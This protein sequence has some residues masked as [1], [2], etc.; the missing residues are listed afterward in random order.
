MGVK[1]SIIKRSFRHKYGNLY[2]NGIQIWE[3]GADH[4]TKWDKKFCLQSVIGI[5]R[6]Q[7]ILCDLSRLI[8][9]R[10]IQ[11]KDKE[12]V[13]RRYYRNWFLLLS[14]FFFQLNRGLYSFAQK[15]RT[16]NL[17]LYQSTQLRCSTC[18]K[19]AGP[20]EIPI[21]FPLY[22]FSSSCLCVCV[23]VDVQVAKLGNVL[24]PIKMFFLS[25]PFCWI[26]SLI[27]LVREDV[28]DLNQEKLYGWWLCKNGD[29]ANV[30]VN[31]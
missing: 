10:S 18:E 31:V 30:S 17:V 19:C 16:T 21:H 8:L 25:L 5:I 20:V 6:N 29:G 28:I 15:L 26:K 3:F 27:F 13:M 1:E 2:W 24:L 22:K 14:S 4:L 23:F 7:V 9:T 11:W 12:T